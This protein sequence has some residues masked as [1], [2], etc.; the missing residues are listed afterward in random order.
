M[1][2]LWIIMNQLFELNFQDIVEIVEEIVNHI[3]YSKGIL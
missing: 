2:R 3:T 1:S